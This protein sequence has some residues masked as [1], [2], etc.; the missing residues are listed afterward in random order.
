MYVPWKSEFKREMFV[1]GL[2]TCAYKWQKKPKEFCQIILGLFGEIFLGFR[3][4]VNTKTHPK[5]SIRK[6]RILTL[7]IVVVSLSAC[8]SR[9]VAKYFVDPRRGVEIFER[10][11]DV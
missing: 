8:C 7:G 3:D 4:L 10:K 6:P 5:T 11:E 1:W 9:H 2:L